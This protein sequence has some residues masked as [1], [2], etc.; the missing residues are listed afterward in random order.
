MGV[1]Q[2][3]VASGKLHAEAYKIMSEEVLKSRS[4]LSSLFAYQYQVIPFVYAHLVSS[5]SFLYLLTLAVVKATRCRP[6]APLLG[7][8]L[9][10]IERIVMGLSP[11]LEPIFMGLSPPFPLLN[12]PN[13]RPPPP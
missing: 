9:G 5:G 3:A 1:L 13:K 8:D 7:A 11:P 6:E 10:A 4:L 2:R 12:S